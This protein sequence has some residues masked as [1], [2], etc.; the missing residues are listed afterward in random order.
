MLWKRKV[1]SGVL[2]EVS[3]TLC[4]RTTKIYV[5][6]E[7]SFQ[8]PLKYID[9]VRRT[10]TAQDVLK[11]HEI[12]VCWNVDGDRKLFGPRTC[13]IQ[14]TSLHNSPL[15]GYMLSGERL[16]NEEISTQRKTTL[17]TRTTEA[18]QCH[19]VQ[20]NLSH[21][22]GRRG[23]RRF[24]SKD[25]RRTLESHMESAIPCKSQKKITKYNV[26]HIKGI[27]S[28]APMR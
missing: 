11:E 8:I 26:K 16:T 7:R 25:A 12:D 17:G 15:Q 5:L 23:I 22:S 21:W 3:S 14:F 2:Q 10:N 1:I 18:R 20:R 27:S 19:K 9:V 28:R 13:F 4:A 24:C 6:Q